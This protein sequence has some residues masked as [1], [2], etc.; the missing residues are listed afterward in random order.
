MDTSSDEGE[1]ESVMDDFFGYESDKCDD[2]IEIQNNIYAFKGLVLSVFS[3]ESEE[4]DDG[5]EDKNIKTNGSYLNGE[6]Y[7]YE[8]TGDESV[9]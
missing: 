2:I 4:S 5:S 8:V 1:V 9:A 6:D 7:F 3:S